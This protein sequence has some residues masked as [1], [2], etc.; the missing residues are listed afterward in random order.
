MVALLRDLK[1]L[2]V[3]QLSMFTFSSSTLNL[4]GAW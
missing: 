4:M 1:S 3:M 2:L